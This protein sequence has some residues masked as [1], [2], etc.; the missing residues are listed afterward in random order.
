M[1]A[2][3][4]EENERKHHYQIFTRELKEFI[5]DFDFSNVDAEAIILE[6]NPDEEIIKYAKNASVLYVGSNGKRALQINVDWCR[7]TDA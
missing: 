2:G 5:K 1:R 6:G 4:N 7:F 3:L